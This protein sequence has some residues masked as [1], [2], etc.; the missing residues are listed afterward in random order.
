[1]A[2]EVTGGDYDLVIVS[3]MPSPWWRRWLE[4]DLVGTLL[5]VAGRPLLVARPAAT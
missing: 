5:R 4:G 1:V 2:R 3:S